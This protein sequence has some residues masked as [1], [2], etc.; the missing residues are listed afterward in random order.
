MNNLTSRKFKLIKVHP[1]AGAIGA[2]IENV[3][4]SSKLDNEVLTEIHKAFL[5]FN[6]IFF[7]DQKFKYF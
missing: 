6:V 4:L 3:N 2:E 1:I 7:R 5:L